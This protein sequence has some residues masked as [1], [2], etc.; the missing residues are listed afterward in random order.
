MSRHFN[1]ELDERRVK[2][3]LQGN[4]MTFSED[5]WNDF[6]QKTKPIEKASTLPSFKINLAINR[7]VLLT[8]AFIILIG[9][10]T[11]VIA[12][13]VDFS[14]T[15]SN[16]ETVREVKPDANNYKLEKLTTAVPKKEVAKPIAT[17]AVTTS[18]FASSTSS[19][20]VPTST[21]QYLANQTNT[22]SSNSQGNSSGSG[23][24]NNLMA[25][26]TPDTAISNTTKK[27]T[28]LTKIPNNYQPRLRKKKKEAETLEAKPLTQELPTTANEEP[29][30]ELK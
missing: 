21:T 28:S 15:K 11:V 29:E 13:F 26:N 23:Q 24:N 4:S 2:D 22:Y 1:Y 5:V 19:S 20:V 18:T 6:L 14:S 7:S 25:R 3:L 16:T 12:K 9:S 27:D 17:T 30:L 8:G 10:F